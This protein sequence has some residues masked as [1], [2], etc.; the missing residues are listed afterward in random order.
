M[1]FLLQLWLC[2]THLSAFSFAQPSFDLNDVISSRQADPTKVGYLSVYWKTGI[3]GVFFAL[4]KNDS[5][6]SFVD[7]NNGTPIVAPTVG[8]KFI[9]DVSIVPGGG[10][11]GQS[12]WYMIGTDLNIGKVTNTKLCIPQ[13]LSSARRYRGIPLSGMVLVVSSLGK[14]TIF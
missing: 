1:K 13:M 2:L 11:E 12:K 9:R 4:S 6:F 10:R 3:N 8:Q 14:V 5:P 7:L